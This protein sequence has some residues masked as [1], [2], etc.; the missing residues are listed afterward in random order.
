MVMGEHLGAEVPAVL[1]LGFRVASGIEM[2]M[3]VLLVLSKAKCFNA[4]KQHRPLQ[5]HMGIHLHGFQVV[6]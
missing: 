2:D 4:L 3:I 1:L 6:F 5:P